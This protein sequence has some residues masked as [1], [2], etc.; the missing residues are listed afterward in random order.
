MSVRR[1]DGPSWKIVKKVV[2][3]KKEQIF[4]KT[5]LGGCFCKEKCGLL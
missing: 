2:P 1:T 5:R 4:K 3:G